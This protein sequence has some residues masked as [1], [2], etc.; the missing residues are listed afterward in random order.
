MYI[1]L[2]TIFVCVVSVC[3]CVHVLG[4]VCVFGCRCICVVGGRGFLYIICYM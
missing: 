2:S 3:M 4:C 1:G